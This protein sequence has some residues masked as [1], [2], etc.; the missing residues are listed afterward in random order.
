MQNLAAAGLSAPQTEHLA[1][2]RVSP[3][4]PSHR[5]AAADCVELLLAET[6]SGIEPGR[7]QVGPGRE[8]QIF[9]IRERI[10]VQ[11]IKT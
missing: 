5:D 8:P 3:I 10:T 9:S 2:P 6:R 4:A 1:I 11:G 7:A